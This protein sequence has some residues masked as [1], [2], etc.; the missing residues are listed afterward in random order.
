ML[1]NN[2]FLLMINFFNNSWLLT[3]FCSIIYINIDVIT[4]FLKNIN[5]IYFINQLTII[6]MLS[7]MTLYTEFFND[8]NFTMKFIIINVHRTSNA[9]SC[10]T[11]SY[12]L[13]QLILFCW[14]KLHFAIYHWTFS[15]QFQRLHFCQTRSLIFLTSRCLLILILWHSLMILLLFCETSFTWWVVTRF[16]V[17]IFSLFSL[18]IFLW[19]IFTFS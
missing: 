14:Q 19:M 8:S 2:L 13:S 11:L 18:R 10:V 16:L 7:N 3:N 6:K 1:V 5:I 12:C 17:R 9:F 4:V 15:W